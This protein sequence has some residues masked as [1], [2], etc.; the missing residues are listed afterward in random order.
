MSANELGKTNES[1]GTH[2]IMAVT[3]PDE[4]YCLHKRSPDVL[5]LRCVDKV[6]DTL[7]SATAPAD[8]DILH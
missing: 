5:V 4:M 6:N 8:T 2:S 3:T 1:Q 7:H